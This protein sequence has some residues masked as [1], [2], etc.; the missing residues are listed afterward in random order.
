M[1]PRPYQ[2][3][4]IQA[5]ADYFKQGVNAV[6]LCAP[7]GS[8]KTVMYSII[9]LKAALKGKKVLILEHRQELI[10]QTSEKLH[11]FG[12]AHGF[13]TPQF[14][15]NKSNI[16]IGSVYTVHRRLQ[17]MDTPDLIIIDEA[18]HSV[19]NTWGDII[20]AFPKAYLIGVTATACRTDGKGLGV[21]SGGFYKKLVNLYDT[22][23]MIKNGFLSPY[24]YYCPDIGFSS[25]GIKTIAGDFDKAEQ[26]KRLNKTTI[27]GC[28]I[29][30]YKNITNGLPA[31]A[32]CSNVKHAEDVARQF[33]DAG[34]PA[35]SIDGTL[36]K[37]ERKR[38]ISD[39]ANGK[40]KVLTSCDIISEGTDIPVVAVAIML[41]LTKSFALYRQWCGRVLRP[42]PGKE[43]A[44]ILDHVGNLFRHGMPD[45]EYEWSL[46]GETKKKKSKTE[47]NEFRVCK[48]CYVPFIYNL[49]VCPHCGQTVQ[50]LERNI[51]HTDGELK[52]ISDVTIKEKKKRYTNE[53]WIELRKIMAECKKKGLGLNAA[54]KIFHINKKRKIGT[55][56]PNK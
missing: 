10:Y 23:Y 19:A 54:Y 9:A 11:A 33:C 34:I 12:V 40:I 15:E 44:V 45:A 20:R 51:D 36:S 27:T 50:I 18:H 38:K 30:H 41:R 53:D 3:E 47:K 1:K 42:Y 39:L 13:I 43:F 49:R 6:L 8:G 14:T 4:Y 2:I 35:E 7:T 22:K 16:K 55:S 31:I 26:E 56:V 32:F 48:F 37:D 29:T 17:K 24:K 25:N 28:V 5:A 46:D 52:E 21:K